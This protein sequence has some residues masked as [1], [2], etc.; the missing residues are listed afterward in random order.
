MSKRIELV[1]FVFCLFY[2]FSI[3]LFAQT[4]SDVVWK[5]NHDATPSFREPVKKNVSKVFLPVM[6]AKEVCAKNSVEVETVYRDDSVKML[7]VFLKPTIIPKELKTH[8]IPFKNT[9]E[10]PI[11][12]LPNFITNKTEF[13]ADGFI[14]SWSNDQFSFFYI[15]TAKCVVFGVKVNPNYYTPDSDYEILRRFFSEAFELSFEIEE[16]FLDEKVFSKKPLQVSAYYKRPIMDNERNQETS[17]GLAGNFMLFTENFS[18]VFFRCEKNISEDIDIDAY[19]RFSKKILM[20]NL[21]PVSAKRIEDEKQKAANNA[22]AQPIPATNPPLDI[23]KTTDAEAKKETQELAKTE[24][25]RLQLIDSLVNKSTWYEYENF[26][27][28]AIT[29]YYLNNTSKQISITESN[30]IKE[31]LKSDNA[32]I[33]AHGI[34]FLAFAKVQN[35]A[36]ILENLFEIETN[37]TN[38][39]SIIYKLSDI[40][41]KQSLTFLQNIQSNESLKPTL[42][43]TARIAITKLEQK[44]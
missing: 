12:M 2:Y 8:L 35:A 29:N 40:G 30:R 25:G 13:C 32:D 24:S 21:V 19:S 9:K 27:R 36:R 37:I 7:S 4:Q 18:T 34:T 15:D 1:V 44:K 3:V 20:D 38:Q 39:E 5:W 14:A 6:P 22:A 10:E 28:I 26:A 42:R 33:R 41:G 17:W 43:K 31:L 16:F 11:I 23:N